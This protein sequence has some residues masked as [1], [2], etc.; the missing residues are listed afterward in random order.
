M[1]IY[2]N[3]PEYQ[4]KPGYTFIP[5]DYAASG[6]TAVPDA[7]P[8][9]ADYYGRHNPLPQNN[10]APQT[11]YGMFSP[12]PSYQQSSDQML[13][14]V[15]KPPSTSFRIDP[16][17]YTPYGG[18]AQTTETPMGGINTRP[19]ARP[20]QPTG[21]TTVQQWSPTQPKPTRPDLGKPELPEYDKRRVSAL[22]QKHA[23]P[24]V[25]RLRQAVQ[26]AGA[27]Y[28]ENPN[29]RRMT[30]REALGGYGQGLERVLAGAHKAAAG[31]YGQ[32]YQAETQAAYGAWQAN[33]QAL[34]GEYNQLFNEY[35]A[36]GTRTT[37]QK[38]TYGSGTGAGGSSSGQVI[39]RAKASMGGIP[40][41]KLALGKYT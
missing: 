39:D 31:E 3:R 41:A 21:S 26:A 4:G 19:G 12:P 32:E 30:M 38:N 18:E 5:N 10:Q 34:M 25:R 33:A 11:S 8:R 15:Q 28:Y 9:T 14:G 27:Q 7:V 37:T 20:L 29:V 6:K 23:A 17:G 35:M 36:S 2:T 22:A 1:T 13:S 16:S 24:E 40:A